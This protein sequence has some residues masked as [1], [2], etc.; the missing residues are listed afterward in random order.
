MADSDSDAIPDYLEEQYGLAP[1]KPSPNSAYL[2][3]HGLT[4]YLHIVKPLDSDG[5]MQETRRS[6]MIS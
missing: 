6:L 1:S 5:V 2:I 3:K 4:S